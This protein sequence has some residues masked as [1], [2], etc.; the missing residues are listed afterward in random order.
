MRDAIEAERGIDRRAIRKG[1]KTSQCPVRDQ[2]RGHCDRRQHENEMAHTVEQHR[3]D[4]DRVRDR[5][6]NREAEQEIAEEVL[7]PA[8]AVTPDQRNDCGDRGND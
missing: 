3:L 7:A 4:R 6:D 1:R 8:P 5:E 2:R